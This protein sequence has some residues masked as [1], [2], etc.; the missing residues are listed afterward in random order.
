MSRMGAKAALAALMIIVSGCAPALK[1]LPAG[2]SSQPPLAWRTQLATTSAVELDWWKRFG[3]SRLTEL[4]EKARANNLDV[5]GAGDFGQRLQGAH[6][7]GGR[8]VMIRADGKEH[9]PGGITLFQY[10]PD[11]RP[12]LRHGRRLTG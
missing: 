9:R 4:V 6:E 5:V 2:V 10:I 12:P 3:D 8:R 7:I 1:P 11:T